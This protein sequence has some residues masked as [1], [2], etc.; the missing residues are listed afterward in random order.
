MYV[1]YCVEPPDAVKG[2]GSALARTCPG[3]RN[4][5]EGEGD[6]RTLIGS[7]EELPEVEP[8]KPSI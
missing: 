8:P 4:V 2:I 6:F 3:L 5:A 1:K 7:G